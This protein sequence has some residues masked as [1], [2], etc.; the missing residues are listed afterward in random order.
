M[1]TIFLLSST[2]CT[3][4]VDAN[5]HLK[6]LNCSL[7]YS[8]QRVQDKGSW[9]QKPKCIFVLMLRL[10]IFAG[11]GR[12]TRWPADSGEFWEACLHLRLAFGRDFYWRRCWRLVQPRRRAVRLSRN[13]VIDRFAASDICSSDYT[14]RLRNNKNSLHVSTDFSS[15]RNFKPSLN[16]IDSKFA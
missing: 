15:L 16:A 3:L 2:Y 4:H 7:S 11:S 9:E 8:F 1:I 10:A 14:G 6:F 5:V 12:L 13:R